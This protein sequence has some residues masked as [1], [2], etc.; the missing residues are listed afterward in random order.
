MTFP[1][2]LAEV[3][4]IDTQELSTKSL[5]TA[6]WRGENSIALYGSKVF[7]KVFPHEST[8]FERVKARS[9]FLRQNCVHNNL[10]R[11]IEVRTTLDGRP[12]IVSEF[13]DGSNLRTRLEDFRS[14]RNAVSLFAKICRGISVLHSFAVM[15]R[16]LKPENVMV[17]E[18]EN[19]RT[20]KD[21]KDMAVKVCDFDTARSVS[22]PRFQSS[23]MGTPRYMAP[24]QIQGKP[25]SL[26]TDIYAIGL[27]LY[28]VLAGRT[29]RSETDLRPS[30]FNRAVRGNLDQ[31]VLS[32]LQIEPSRRCSI[33]QLL[34]ALEEFSYDCIS[35]KSYPLIASIPQKKY[36]LFSVGEFS[37]DVVPLIGGDA[38]H[39]YVYPH[40]IKVEDDT[41]NLQEVPN[42][43]LDA[44]E[45]WLRWREADA[46]RRTAPF[47]NR[48]QPRVVNVGAGLTE[49]REE[50]LYPLKLRLGVTDYFNTQCTNFAINLLLPN[51]QSIGEVYGGDHN[52]FESSGLANPLATNFSVVTCGDPQKYIFTTQ[53]GKMVGG[54]PEFDPWNRVPA[55]SGTGHPLYDQD[56]ETKVFCPFQAGLREATEENL[57]DYALS[58]E[59]IVFFGFA[60]TG[61][62]M[63]PFLFGEI[64]LRNLTASQF[65]SERIIHRNDVFDKEG[66]PF[67]IEDVT[68]WIRELYLRFDKDGKN[69]SRPSHTGIF[70]LYQSLIYE[71]PDQIPYI[72]SRLK[73]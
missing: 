24:E 2:H 47:E 72:N 48:R 25:L 65:R 40:G 61:L 26:A 51:G 18:N 22:A 29:L 73:V 53:R 59:E 30:R 20:T 41:E 55:I 49:G 34:T 38:V 31:I 60:R 45:D 8:W 63:F 17:F 21:F 3:V 52:E 50:R 1:E 27:M 36:P 37:L 9:A 23:Q 54:N 7:I 10:A 14:P 68:E 66:R 57:G 43:L 62:M 67:T 56:P 64:R 4:Q 70:S 33:S 42:E 46:N 12:M 58:P 69:V 6:I 16:D 13:V 32:C 5:F 39:R 44:T 35:S 28:E 15:H 11:I 71:Y 19:F